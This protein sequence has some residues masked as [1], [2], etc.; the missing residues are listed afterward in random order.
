MGSR[1]FGVIRHD[2]TTSCACGAWSPTCSVT[3]GMLFANRCTWAHPLA[4]STQ[5]LGVDAAGWLGEG[6]LAAVQGRGDPQ[7]LR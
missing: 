4:T 5:A 2:D 7:V 3:F 6:E 1:G